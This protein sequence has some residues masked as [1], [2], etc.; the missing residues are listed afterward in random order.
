MPSMQNPSAILLDLD[1]TI[2]HLNGGYETLYE[3]LTEYKIPRYEAKTA[4]RKTA[5][6]VEGFTL[7]SYVACLA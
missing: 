1:F 6:S 7:E 4:L 2:A 5:D 3:A